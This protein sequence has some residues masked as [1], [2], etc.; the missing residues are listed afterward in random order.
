MIGEGT[1][2]RI[3]V[4]GGTGHVGARVAAALRDVDGVEVVST[5]RRGRFSL[6][7]ADPASF[8]FR[9]GDVVVNCADTVG[10]SPRR[11]YE[12]CLSRELTLVECTADASA[13]LDLY[14][15]FGSTPPKERR[16]QFVL[17]V[18]GYPGLSNTLARHVFTPGVTTKLELFISWSV[19]SGAGHGTCKLMAEALGSPSLNIRDGQEVWG[20]P[21]SEVWGC[22]YF[23]GARWG[24]ELGLPESLLLHRSTGVPNVATYAFNRPPLPRFALGLVSW[25]ARRG[26]FR[27]K[28]VRASALLGFRALRSLLLS[29]RSTRVHMVARG[30]YEE[31]KV[32]ESELEAED[33]FDAVGFAIASACMLIGER[34]H[35]PGLHHCDE[36]LPLESWVERMRALGCA[37]IVWRDRGS[38]ATK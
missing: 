2:L 3:V 30:V 37:P 33:A 34:G 28:L 17:G 25:L 29:G 36:I 19:L 15:L 31:G 11:L 24:L 4:V 35:R 6:D 1:S 27:W 13:Y 21:L 16:A 18:G 5:S 14:E 22:P 10:T 12:Y 20:P 38:L 26:V 23:S 9:D 8:D 7:L 32:K